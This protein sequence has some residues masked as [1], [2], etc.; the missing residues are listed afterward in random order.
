MSSVYPLGYSNIGNYPIYQ[1]LN[2]DAQIAFAINQIL[3]TGYGLPIQKAI[4]MTLGEQEVNQALSLFRQIQSPST[5]LEVFQSA[6]SPGNH[7]DHCDLAR[8]FYYILP[9]DLQNEFKRQLLIA[10]NYSDDGLGSDFGQI[11]VDNGFTHKPLAV[12]AV[13]AMR[14]AIANT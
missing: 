4:S 1:P 7:A 11:V 5:K 8:K 13:Q 2:A 6:I 9:T 14:L 12:K 3:F 10:N